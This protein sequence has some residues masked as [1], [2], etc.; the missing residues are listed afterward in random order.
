M[1]S[2]MGRTPTLSAALW[3]TLAGLGLA[4]C[5]SNDQA[6]HLADAF[7]GPVAGLPSAP[8]SATAECGVAMPPTADLVIA[9]TGGSELVITEAI[10]DGG[11]AVTTTLPLRIAAGAQGSLAVRPPAAVIGTDRGGT[12]KSGTLT[13]TTNEPT[14]TRTVALSAKVLGPNLAF[15]D[16]GG[17]PITLL[18][19]SPT[20][21]CPA[22]LAVFLRNTGTA[23]LTVGAAVASGF[24]FGGF[25]GGVLEPGASATQQ[26]RPRTDSACTVSDTIIYQVTGNTCGSSTAALAGVFEITPQGG[27]ST[28]FC[29]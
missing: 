22:P 9:N 27:A 24:A 17:A 18:L 29:S 6:G 23:P 5:G 25:S 19:Q 8:L 7:T 12:T 14:P 10:A 3:S 20:G 2:K 28:C 15:T 21:T 26:I 16:A 4:A 13:L 11:F 1:V